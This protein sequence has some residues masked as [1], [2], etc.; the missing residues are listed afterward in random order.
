MF[1]NLHFWSQQTLQLK[2]PWME[3]VLG[4]IPM[5]FHESQ[6][7]LNPWQNYWGRRLLV[8]A[9]PPPKIVLL[10]HNMTLWRCEGRL[11]AVGASFLGGDVINGQKV[12]LPTIFNGPVQILPVLSNLTMFVHG[13]QRS[14]KVGL[15]TKKLLSIHPTITRH[16]NPLSAA[17]QSIWRCFTLHC[18]PQFYQNDKHSVNIVY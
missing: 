17:Q 6:L 18:R 2:T 8:C 10:V 14:S 9:C 15:F 5:V 11:R 7:A 13:I 16:T 1:E 12:T 4:S 3:K